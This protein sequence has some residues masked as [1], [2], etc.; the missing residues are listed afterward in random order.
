MTGS[1]VRA[2]WRTCAM[3]A[4]TSLRAEVIRLFVVTCRTSDSR[5]A[6]MRG[7]SYHVAHAFSAHI[8]DSTGQSVRCTPVPRIVCTRLTQSETQ[9]E[10]RNALGH[11]LAGTHAAYAD[12]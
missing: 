6:C 2:S 3:V 9:T 11:Y 5:V 8:A 12:R 10:S 1:G 4:S 7:I